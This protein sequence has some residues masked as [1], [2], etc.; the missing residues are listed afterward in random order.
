MQKIV[1]M[2]AWEFA[3]RGAVLMKLQ[4]LKDGVDREESEDDDASVA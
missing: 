3:R 1:Y 4:E 2:R